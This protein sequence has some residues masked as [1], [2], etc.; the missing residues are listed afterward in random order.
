MTAAPRLILA[1]ILCILPLAAG[2]ECLP[3]K[4]KP[5][6]TTEDITLD[7]LMCEHEKQLKALGANRPELP[8]PADELLNDR[9]ALDEVEVETSPFVTRTLRTQ[10]SLDSMSDMNARTGDRFKALTPRRLP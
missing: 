5:L 1:L 7:Y 3:T 6:R 9:G 8:P 4:G 2:A 10:R